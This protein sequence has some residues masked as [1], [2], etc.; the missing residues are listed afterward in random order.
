M[1]MVQFQRDNDLLNATRSPPTASKQ[2][3]V[4]PS[5]YSVMH[6]QEKQEVPL[7]LHRLRNVLFPEVAADLQSF[8]KGRAQSFR[9]ALDDTC[10]NG[11]NWRSV[12][13]AP[14]IRAVVSPEYVADDQRWW[15]WKYGSA[16]FIPH[17]LFHSPF[18]TSDW[19]S[20]DAIVVIFFA[21]HHS[22][23]P[24]ITQQQCLQRLQRDSSAFR[25][26]NGSRHFFIFTGD[27]GPCCIDGRYKDVDFL[28]YRIIGNHGQVGVMHQAARL[29]LAPP[30]PCFDR[31]KDISIPT[32]SLHEPLVPNG[33]RPVYAA[34]NF[35]SRPVLI[36]A[37]GEN[38]YSECRKAL[39][40][41]FEG[42]ALDSE[43]VV[44]R[45]LPNNETS[46]LML[47][48]RFCV[49]CSGFAPWTQRLF[50]AMHAGCVPLVITE[51]WI[52][53]F[54]ELLN[55]SKFSATLPLAR[56]KE[57]PHYARSLDHNA[58]Q[59]GVFQ[60][61]AAMRY[62]LGP[63][64]GGEDMLPLL[65]YEI[66]RRLR[67]DPTES[68]AF[69][70]TV[71]SG[72]Q[73]DGAYDNASLTVR[74]IPAVDGM[75]ELQSTH[76]IYGANRFRCWTRIG[77]TC[78]CERAMNGTPSSPVP[79]YL[80]HNLKMKWPPRHPTTNESRVLA[81]GYAKVWQ[82]DSATWVHEH[83]ADTYF[84]S[85][86]PLNKDGAGT[87]LHKTYPRSGDCIEGAIM[88]SM[89]VKKVGSYTSR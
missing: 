7:I 61:R 55:Y 86:D 54:D 2:E 37:V 9:I 27:Q 20:A 52:L 50:E 83:F 36:S 5:S 79:D 4:R 59:R 38:R 14:P 85:W 71:T 15:G 31:K 24:A 3:R 23:R 73:T 87:C 39:L 80:L 21:H 48:S 35:G 10:M 16:G 49:I 12:W 18:M 46:A 69:V 28:R 81:R 17:M 56:I 68:A 13:D 67:Y 33:T 25:E 41:V 1:M 78:E 72:V 66:S 63:T 60:A 6:A 84:I 8:F 26:T 74:R 82:M 64:Y 43:V 47:R 89:G 53:P 75:I 77:Q 45:A 88:P 51:R 58:L 76:T 65:V 57:L 34:V 11:R 44:R 19:Q 29:G 70:R 22:G 30:I 42:E 62:A 32:P 40:E